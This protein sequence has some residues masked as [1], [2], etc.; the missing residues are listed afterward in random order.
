[1]C[2]ETVEIPMM[3]LFFCPVD[4]KTFSLQDDQLQKNNQRPIEFETFAKIL[5]KTSHG[6]NEQG[7]NRV[8]HKTKTLNGWLRAPAHKY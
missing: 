6:A 7:Q 2:E 1:M 8:G 5:C 4:G 3:E